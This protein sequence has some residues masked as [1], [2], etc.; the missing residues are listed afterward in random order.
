MILEAMLGIEELIARTPG[1]LARLNSPPIAN[2]ELAKS[3]RIFW[4]YFDTQDEDSDLVRP[5]FVL[6]EAELHYS[7]VNLDELQGVA[8]VDVTYTEDAT[9]V[10]DHK[11]SKLYFLDFVSD[12]LDSIA[13]RQGQAIDGTDAEVY[14]S[15]HRILLTQQA[16]RSPK[17]HRDPDRP[18]TD[19]WWCK[20][21]MWIGEPEAV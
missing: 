2:Y 14:I 21:R 3:Q 12:M 10:D 17:S 7:I 19:Y 11:A 6:Q 15:V 9:S 8:V 5:H 13:L 4:D 16:V 20:W 1:L 18:A